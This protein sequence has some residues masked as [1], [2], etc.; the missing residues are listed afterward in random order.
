LDRFQAL[1]VLKLWAKSE[2]I[3]SGA[4]ND[5]IEL[6]VIA[7]AAL[8][9]S[10][11]RIPTPFAKVTYYGPN[12]FGGAMLVS[13]HKTDVSPKTQ[14]PIWNK[15]FSLTIQPNSKFINIEVCDKFAGMDK[16][17][18]TAKLA[19]SFIPGI[20][21]NLLDR[22]LVYGYDG[23]IHPPFQGFNEVLTFASRRSRVA[24]DRL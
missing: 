15:P 6:T 11:F 19:F 22:S 7:A 9:R 18:A 24:D 23:M 3:L 5:Q 10:S 4:E 16:Q 21:A 20:E 17:L 14:N 12:R 13:E 1:E 8:S 2:N